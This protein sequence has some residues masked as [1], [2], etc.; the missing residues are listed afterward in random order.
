MDFY[1]GKRISANTLFHFTDSFDNLAGIFSHCFYP[2]YCL[3]DQSYLVEDYLPQYVA[4]PMVCFCDLPLSQVHYHT[5]TYG[6]YCIGL[7][8]EW[9]QAKG[10]NP[11]MY[12]L[13]NSYS[14]LLLKKCFGQL[15]PLNPELLRYKPEQ[16]DLAAQNVATMLYSFFTFL[17]PYEGEV[18]KNGEQIKSK[19]RFYDE[20]EWR[21]VPALDRLN[22]LGLIPVMSQQHYK[23]DGTRK[24]GNIILRESFQ[25]NFSARDVKYII[26]KEEDEVLRIADKINAL[27]SRYSQEEIKLLSTH[28]ISMQQIREDF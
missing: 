13:P 14:T 11:I 22:Q 20:R 15:Y 21:Y 6:S 8:K 5:E 27:A 1:Q 10:I 7:S 2:R 23:E 12:A 19:V 26:V 9:G 3:E 25:L 17:K 4:I 18:W 24:H 16:R 28:I